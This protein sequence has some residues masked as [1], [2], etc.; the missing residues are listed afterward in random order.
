MSKPREP[1]GSLL[2]TLVLTPVGSPVTSI[3]VAVRGMPG[4][5]LSVDV[6]AI[7]DL[8]C[9]VDA[10]TGGDATSALVPLLRQFFEVADRP[11]ETDGTWR[12]AAEYR[13]REDHLRAAVGARPRVRR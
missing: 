7:R 2:D 11:C 8:R 4:V 12:H 9:S 13:R 5:R 10:L 1:S 3:D 6:S